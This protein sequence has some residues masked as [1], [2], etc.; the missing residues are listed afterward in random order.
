MGQNKLFRFFGWALILISICLV[1]VTVKAMSYDV[2]Y[3]MQIQ[4]VL[5]TLFFFGGGLFILFR[6]K[7]K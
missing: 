2:D 7:K 5:M 1:L 4:R 3:S 6:E